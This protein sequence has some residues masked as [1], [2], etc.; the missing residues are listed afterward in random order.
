MVMIRIGPSF[1][2]YFPLHFSVKLKLLGE[3]K[4]VICIKAILILQMKAKDDNTI[5]WNWSSQ[6][7]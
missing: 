3:K 2:L 7:A 1:A 5:P 6:E 4:G